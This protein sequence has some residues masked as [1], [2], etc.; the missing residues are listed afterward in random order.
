[1]NPGYAEKYGVD[2]KNIDY[3]IRGKIKTGAD[4]ITRPAPGLGSNAGG[5][6]EIVTNPYDVIIDSFIMP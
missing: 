6:L 4:F 1:M 3:I 5:A 2:F